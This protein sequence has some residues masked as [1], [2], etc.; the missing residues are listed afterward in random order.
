MGLIF[1]ARNVLDLKVNPGVVMQLFASDIYI[2]LI[3]KMGHYSVVFRS[4]SVSGSRNK[5]RFLSVLASTAD[6]PYE[7]LRA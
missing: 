2:G 4:G 3:R 1:L 6:E 7:W 5:D